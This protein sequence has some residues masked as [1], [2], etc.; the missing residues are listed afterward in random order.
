MISKTENNSL[1]A[2]AISKGIRDGAMASEIDP[3]TKAKIK[4]IFISHAAAETM[5]VQEFTDTLVQL[6]AKHILL[7]KNEMISFVLHIIMECAGGMS[8]AGRKQMIE[9]GDMKLMKEVVSESSSDEEK[10]G[11]GKN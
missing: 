9:N 8:G 10:G 6:S 2:V 3:A 5:T 1:A 7:M 11:K 4:A